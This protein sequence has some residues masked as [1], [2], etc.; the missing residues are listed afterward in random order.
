MCYV[1]RLSR[2]LRTFNKP[3]GS[4]WDMDRDSSLSTSGRVRDVTILFGVW[5]VENP[6][7][8]SLPLYKEGMFKMNSGRYTNKRL[9]GWNLPVRRLFSKI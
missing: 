7:N 6:E 3:F 1:P 8:P 2:H 5:I 4:R 9:V